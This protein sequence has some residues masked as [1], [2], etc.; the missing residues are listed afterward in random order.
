VVKRLG[1]CGAPPR[2]ISERDETFGRCRDGA[3]LSVRAVPKRE[4]APQESPPYHRDIINFDF[5]PASFGPIKA[6]EA[7]RARMERPRRPWPAGGGD[8]LG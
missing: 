4:H 3:A 6:T 2:A 5:D 1:R 7:V 8:M